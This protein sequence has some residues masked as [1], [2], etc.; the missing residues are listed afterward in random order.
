MGGSLRYNDSS[1]LENHHI[2]TAFKVMQDKE[3]CTSQKISFEHRA[4]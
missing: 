4:V 3:Y 2:S 1:V